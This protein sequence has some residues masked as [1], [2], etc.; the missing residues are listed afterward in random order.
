MLIYP[1]FSGCGIFT[2]MRGN[3]WKCGRKWPKFNLWH[4]SFWISL[5]VFL[6][7]GVHSPRAFLSGSDY[8][9]SRFLWKRDSPWLFNHPFSGGSLNIWCVIIINFLGNK[10]ERVF[11]KAKIKPASDTT[12][13][14]EPFSE[15]GSH[16]KPSYSLALSPSPF[17]WDHFVLIYWDDR[18]C[19]RSFPRGRDHSLP[20]S[21][22]KTF[23]HRYF[24]AL[25]FPFMSIRLEF[26]VS[27]SWL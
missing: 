1:R 7:F 13:T 15:D 6:A 20:F 9:S 25:F 22:V 12:F 21:Q 26:M 11:K 10:V 16:A 3:E 18:S 24:R 5:Q 14:T 17:Y 8:E 27:G 23:S 4:Q 2:L 19:E